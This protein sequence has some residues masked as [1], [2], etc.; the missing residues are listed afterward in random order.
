MAGISSDVYLN[1]ISDLEYAVKLACT[2]LPLKFKCP[3]AVYLPYEMSSFIV[4]YLLLLQYTH[5]H[6]D[7][8]TDKAL[9]PCGGAFYYPSKV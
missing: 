4:L 9:Q 2:V 8:S 1:S 3:E 5:A 6:Q 7:P